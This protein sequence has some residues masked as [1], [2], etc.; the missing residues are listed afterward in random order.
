MSVVS[1]L[2]ISPKRNW[3][4]LI[5]SMKSDAERKHLDPMLLAESN[6]RPRKLRWANIARASE[7]N[8]GI[9]K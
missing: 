9:F 2:G 3:L 1:S 4:G 6:P 7:S 5:E 8:P